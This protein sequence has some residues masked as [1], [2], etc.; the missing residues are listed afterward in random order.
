M[1][2]GRL[3]REPV[4][5]AWIGEGAFAPSTAVAP[6]DRAVGARSREMLLPFDLM[7]RIIPGTFSG[8]PFSETLT[9]V[10]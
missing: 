5:V 2:A 10:R 8:A 1:D 3:E 4:I 9:F 6:C 7:P